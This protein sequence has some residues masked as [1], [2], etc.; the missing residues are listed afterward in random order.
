MV[1]KINKR[2]YFFSLD[3]LIALIVILG[4][5]LLIRPSTTQV[6]QEVNLQKDLL[7]VLSSLKIGEIDNSYVQSLILDGSITNLNQSVLE[8][9]GDFYANSDNRASILTESI[10]ND[11]N[12]NENIGLYFDNMEIAT[13]G[14]TPFSNAEDVWTSRQIISGIRQGEGVTGYSARAFLSAENKVNYFYF[15]GYVGDGNITIDLGQDVLSAKVEAVFSEDF[16]ASINNGPKT[17]HFPTPETP[18][19]FTINSGFSSGDNYLYFESG[20][21]LYIA[22]GFIK[23]SYNN[24]ELLQNTTQ[25]KLPGIEG[26]INLYDSFYVPG[27]LESMEVLLSYTSPYNLFLNIGNQTVYRGNGSNIQTTINDATLRSILDYSIMNDKTIPFRI[28]L[29][30]VSYV[31]NISRDA[32]VFSVTDLSGSMR[33]SCF[34]PDLFCCFRCRFPQ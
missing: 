19:S 14:S 15:G 33:A 20:N 9:I 6:T 13:Y 26:L 17:S 21:N 2:G 16:N 12:L 22:G 3:A 11:L 7:V 8:Q 24:S 31:L 29:E 30:N 4:V 10:L 25:H 28:G 18:Y 27:E 34:N 5:V 32:D 23:I 1:M